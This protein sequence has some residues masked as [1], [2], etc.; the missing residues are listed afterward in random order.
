MLQSQFSFHGYIKCMSFQLSSDLFP[1]L[2]THFSE[3]EPD[4]L[5]HTVSIRFWYP[6]YRKLHDVGMN[7][8]LWQLYLN[9]VSLD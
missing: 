3:C 4:F 2:K 8:P 1:L 9:V 5:I 6:S 7:S